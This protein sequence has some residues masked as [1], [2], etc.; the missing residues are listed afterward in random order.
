MVGI[1]DDDDEMMDESMGRKAPHPSQR[2]RGKQWGVRSEQH[3]ETAV[4]ASSSEPA[5]AVGMG[6]TPPI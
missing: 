6:Y 1:S 2:S 5:V 3:G 4:A